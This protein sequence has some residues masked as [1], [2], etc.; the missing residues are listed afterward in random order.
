M[1]EAA[2]VSLHPAYALHRR[3]YRETSLLI[4]LFTAEH[5]RVG[6]IAR[7]VR[8][9][10]G[11]QQGLLQPFTPL[12]V[13]WSAPGELATMT[14]VE[15]RQ[16]FPPLHGL[17]LI[18]AF[19]VNELLLRLLHRHEP[20]EELFLAYELVLRR[21]A[22]DAEHQEWH[23]RLFEK[24]LLQELG[25]GLILDHTAD[26]GI[27]LQPDIRYNYL[28]Q[29]GPVPFA[30][31]RQGISVHG[32]TLLTLAE[33]SPPDARTLAEAKRLMR[34]ELHSHLGERPLRSRELFRDA[35]SN[36][37]PRAEP[38]IEEDPSEQSE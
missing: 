26:G 23:L 29:Y 1:T 27:P 33:E 25:Y 11:A 4:E 19:Y 24:T 18:S 2:R 15:A 37:T 30:P 34:N 22:C 36:L 38:I 6:M 9:G 10:K 28:P 7:G 8:R 3:P 21:L 31:E 17:G 20:H 35:I 16:S 14:G 13:S 32:A 12:L 5:G